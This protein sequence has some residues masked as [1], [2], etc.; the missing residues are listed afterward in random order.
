VPLVTVSDA[1]Y[2]ASRVVSS[3]VPRFSKP[4]ATVSVPL[5]A[6]PSPRMTID[7]VLPVSS[8][9]LIR[10]LPRTSSVPVLVNDAFTV[11]VFSSSVPS[12]IRR[13]GPWIVLL[14][15][16]R[17]IWE[18]RSSADSSVSVELA[19]WRTR[20]AAERSVPLWISVVDDMPRLPPTR[21]IVPLLRCVAPLRLSERS[22]ATRTVP[23]LSSSAVNVRAPPAPTLLSIRPGSP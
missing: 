21:S 6:A 20:P 17:E 22:C 15:R 23:R 13:P 19:S 10:L 3:I 16:P 12:L 4:L 18:V 11:V 9:P 1:L 14:D 8:P 7:E 5:L 2:D